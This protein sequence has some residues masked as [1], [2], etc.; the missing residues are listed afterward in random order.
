M[1]TQKEKGFKEI[2][3]QRNVIYDLWLQ[4]A[5]VVQ[6][7]K[8]EALESTYLVLNSNS[9]VTWLSDKYKFINYLKSQF[10]HLSNG[11]LGA[12]SFTEK[13]NEMMTSCFNRITLDNISSIDGEY[14][15]L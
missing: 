12:Y 1:Q 15:K 4:R 6:C 8:P 14:S 2:R 13:L 7:L 5:S 10:P 3:H 11:R 9:T